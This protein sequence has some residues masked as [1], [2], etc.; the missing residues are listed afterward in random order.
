MHTEITYI[1]DND[2]HAMTVVVDRE[3]TLPEAWEYLAEMWSGTGD[4]WSTDDVQLNYTVTI[5]LIE[6]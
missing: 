3:L 2:G 6:K 5:K 4:E 1:S